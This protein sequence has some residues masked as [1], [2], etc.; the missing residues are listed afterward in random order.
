[1]DDMTESPRSMLKEYA[2]TLIAN[3]QASTQKEQDEVAD[4]LID[5]TGKMEAHGKE[6]AQTIHELLGEGGRPEAQ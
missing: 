5:I 4:A 6:I 3:S 1:M 2:E